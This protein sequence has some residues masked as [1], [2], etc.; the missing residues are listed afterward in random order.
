MLWKFREVAGEDA[1]IDA[2]LLTGGMSR[3]WFVEDRL[4]EFFAPDMIFSLS[5]SPAYSRS[6]GACIF[7]S[8]LDP[9]IK[10]IVSPSEI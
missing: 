3:L 2:V 4:K 5:D 10:W 8:L 9:R 6:I 1:N 7:H